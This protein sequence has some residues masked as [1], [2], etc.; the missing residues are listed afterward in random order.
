LKRI[1]TGDMQ[2]HGPLVRKVGPGKDKEYKLKKPPPHLNS[3]IRRYEGGFQE[4][5]GGV[6]EKSAECAGT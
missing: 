3:M 4:G 5:E 6:F 1:Q 2:L